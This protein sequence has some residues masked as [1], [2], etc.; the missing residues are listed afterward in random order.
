M[1]KFK[2]FHIDILFDTPIQIQILPIAPIMAFTAGFFFFF[3]F[4]RSRIQTRITD[5]HAFLVLFIV[6]QIFSYLS[7]FMILTFLKSTVSLFVWYFLI[8]RSKLLIFFMV[9]YISDSM[10]WIF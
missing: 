6:E 10:S 1:A 7:S 2:K 4:F 9:S 3:F 5:F 8:V